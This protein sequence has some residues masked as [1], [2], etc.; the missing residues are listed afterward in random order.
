MIEPY[1]RVEKLIGINFSRPKSTIQLASE[2]IGTIITAS[3]KEIFLMGGK[4][5]KKI[6]GKINSSTAGEKTNSML[7]MNATTIISTGRLTKIK[8]S[9]RLI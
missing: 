2:K 6:P 9:K 3:S 4:N 8:V 7:L 1:N 5:N